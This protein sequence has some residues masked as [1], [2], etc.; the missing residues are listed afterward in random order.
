M[1]VNAPTSSS[2]LSTTAGPPN[3]AAVPVERAPVPS[4]DSG[5]LSARPGEGTEVV[6]REVVGQQ[7]AVAEEVLRDDAVLLGG[8]VEAVVDAADGGPEHAGVLRGL[9][10][11]HEL[12]ALVEEVA[13]GHGQVLLPL[14]HGQVLDLAEQVGVGEEVLLVLGEAVVALLPHDGAEVAEDAERVGHA[15]GVRVPGR[16]A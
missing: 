13:H 1:S 2:G 5:P 6:L 12:A 16:V 8:A 3:G 10:R 11:V 9:A 4:T 15:L 7:Q 14:G